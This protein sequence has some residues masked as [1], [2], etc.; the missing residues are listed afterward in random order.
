[1]IS[2]LCGIPRQV[3]GPGHD[4][5]VLVVVS[6]LPA[7]GKSE[8]ADALGQR[9]GAAVLSVDPIEAA[10]WRCGIAPSFETGV[11]A[12]EVVA[13]V[14]EHQLRLGL[15]VIADAVSS[16]EVAR[17]MWRG[18]ASR[19]GAAMQVVEVICSDEGA[20]RERLAR[21]ARNIDGFPEPSWEDVVRRRD[22]W[23]PWQD[24]RL[25]VDSARELEEN[26][27]EVLA[28]VNR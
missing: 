9:L 4:E 13:V 21:R 27:A 24:E 5:G 28:F 3:C 1:V 8:L 18:A 14:A 10:M 15:T 25:V 22:E 16:L 7:V 11:A 20:H 12:Y 19:T 2:G 6:G 17:D 26:A 23:E